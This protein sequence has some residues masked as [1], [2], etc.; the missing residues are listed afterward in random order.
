MLFIYNSVH[1]PD[2]C[3]HITRAAANGIGVMAMK[4]M[5]GR[6]RDKIKALV[7]DRTTFS[8][9]AIRWAL[10]D[11]AVNTV[12]ITMRTFEHVDEYLGASGTTLTGDD[13]KVLTA[14]ARAVDNQYCR[15]GCSTC[16]ASC[17]AQV[18]I[19]DVMRCGMYYE[20]Y[21]E[22]HK[23]MFEYAS[24]DPA[25]RAHPCR[26]CSAPCESACPHQLEIR[27]RLVRYHDVLMA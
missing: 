19:N 27:R 3:E 18:A 14:Y 23:A 8:Q 15:I 9:A 12:T 16:H 13:E 4:T 26:Q 17:P 24:L 7:D 1:Y 11:P 6:Q 25:R 21:R 10:T 2:R 22:E 5:A 20:S